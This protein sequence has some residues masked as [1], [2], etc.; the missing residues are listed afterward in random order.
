[1]T[2]KRKI[3]I[4]LIVLFSLICL[5]IA[6]LQ[7]LTL[8]SCSVL[9]ETNQVKLKTVIFFESIEDARSNFY[10]NDFRKKFRDVLGEVRLLNMS[11]RNKNQFA[12]FFN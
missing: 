8:T 2:R 10:S 7:S 5:L 1:M 4:S 12:V 3:I 9:Y 11:C 6:Y